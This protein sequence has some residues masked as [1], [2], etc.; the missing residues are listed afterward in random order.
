M[1]AGGETLST[2]AMDDAAAMEGALVMQRQQR[3]KARQRCNGDN[4][5]GNERRNRATAVAAMVGTTSAM[6]ANG[7]TTIN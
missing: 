2:E 1:A 4:G 7:K 3:L 6:A 5:N